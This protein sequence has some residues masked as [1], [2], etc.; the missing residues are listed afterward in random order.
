MTNHHIFQAFIVLACAIAAAAGAV[1]RPTYGAPVYVQPS[2]DE[3]A[4][5]SYQYGVNDGYS[6]A[7]FN[8]DE[9]AD[10]HGNVEGSYRY[11]IFL[12]TSD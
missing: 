2:Y 3:P 10:G 7:N 4:S 9:T 5:Y 12:V 6:G 8:A 11:Y 1:V